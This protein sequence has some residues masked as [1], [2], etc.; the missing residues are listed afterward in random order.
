MAR[1]NVTTPNGFEEMTYTELLGLHNKIT[2][3]LQEKKASEKAAM[4][5]RLEAMAKKGGFDFRELIGKPGARGSRGGKVAPKYRDPS[6][7]ENT[8][9]G[10]GREPRWLVAA[11]KGG[12]AKR[13]D[14]LI[15]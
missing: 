10:R 1:L 13:E 14:F 2:Q 8:W 15:T 11:I 5:E 6:N 9:T 4:R 12:R 7:P 3:L